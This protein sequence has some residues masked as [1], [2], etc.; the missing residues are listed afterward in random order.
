MKSGSESSIS[1]A[2]DNTKDIKQESI[3]R[4]ES[5]DKNDENKTIRKDI[6]DIPESN[7]SKRGSLTSAKS[8]HELKRD[9]ML[10]ESLGSQDSKGDNSDAKVSN[11]DGS[12]TSKG[13][14]YFKI[15]FNSFQLF[16]IINYFKF[17]NYKPYKLTNHI[18]LHCIEKSLK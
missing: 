18:E 2:C 7:M 15:K 17:S 8:L 11:E 1:E 13:I 5:I 6:L 3:E 10:D 12:G 16:Q 9:P 4:E 14:H